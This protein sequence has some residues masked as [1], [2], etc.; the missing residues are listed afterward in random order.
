MNSCI[1]ILLCFLSWLAMSIYKARQIIIKK[2][3]TI[4]YKYDTDEF[5]KFIMYEAA[6]NLFMH[7]MLPSGYLANRL[8]KRY[9]RYKRLEAE[10]KDLRTGTV[11]KK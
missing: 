2:R 9:E 5:H 10:C 11:N 3:K 4:V 8:M 6:N 1:F 7:M